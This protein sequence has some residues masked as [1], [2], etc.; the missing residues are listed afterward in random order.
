MTEDDSLKKILEHNRGEEKKHASILLEW[1]RRNDGTFA[2]ESKAN[3]FRE[4]MKM[5][6]L[7][8][9]SEKALPFVRLN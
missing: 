5:F 2:K 1:I 9:E 3:L 7:T 6:D 4:K 8:A